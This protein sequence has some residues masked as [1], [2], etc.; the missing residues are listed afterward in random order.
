MKALNDLVFEESYNSEYE[1]W[2]SAST[3]KCYKVPIEITRNFNEMK[4]L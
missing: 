2:S 3:G 4:E 1:I